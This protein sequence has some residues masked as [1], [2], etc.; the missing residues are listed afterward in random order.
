MAPRLFDDVLKIKDGG[1]ESD[2][3]LRMT[4]IYVASEASAEP[5]K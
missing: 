5:E 4:R 2:C 1:I 3:R